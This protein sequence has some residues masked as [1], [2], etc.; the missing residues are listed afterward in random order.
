MVK[1]FDIGTKVIYENSIWK[2]F[3]R[4]FFNDELSTYILK[5]KLK[6]VI[7]DISPSLVYKLPN[8]YDLFQMI[9]NKE[10]VIVKTKEKLKKIEKQK[11]ELDNIIKDK[12]GT[13]E[14]LELHNIN[15][16]NRCK[17]YDDIKEIM[18]KYIDDDEWQQSH[19]KDIV[20]AIKNMPHNY[21]FTDNA[22]HTYQ[23]TAFESG[24]NH[25]YYNGDTLWDCLI[26][27]GLISN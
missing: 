17:D 13:I 24:G 12:E 7:N 9:K 1:V 23:I 6:E 20:N 10:I 5:N 8:K 26:E 19:M 4:N 25:K 2:I 16:I 14:K 11:D 21:K 3:G 18:R 15:L 22:N 27:A